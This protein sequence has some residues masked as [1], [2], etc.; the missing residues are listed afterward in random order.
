MAS[1]LDGKIGP[2]NTDTF[3]SITSHYDMEHLKSLR[4]EADGILFG[5]GT[6]RT[7]PKVHQ[8]HDISR[9][10][11]HFIMSN[12][13]DLDIDSPLFQASDIPL[14]I[15][16]NSNSVAHQ[17]PVHV[18]V[19]PMP[20]EGDQIRF[21]SNHI[22]ALGIKALLVEGGGHVLYQFI[23]AGILQE[24]YLTLAPELVGQLN[25][26]GLLGDQ[27]LTHPPKLNLLSSRQIES[28][29]YLHFKLNYSVIGSNPQTQ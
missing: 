24:L 16:T 22:K 20:S 12:G 14:T 7:W 9:K 11:H 15:F 13:L 25:A 26:P 23:E 8:G 4:D 6:F 29:L 17:F 1:S 3:V 21:I 28:E 10:P 19:V 5:A 2:A 18:T 27:T